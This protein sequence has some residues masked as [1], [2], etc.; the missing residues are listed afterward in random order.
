[1]ASTHANLLEGNKAFTLEKSSTPIG[2]V[3]YINMAAASVLWN[4]NVAVVTS[5]KCALRARCRTWGR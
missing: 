2:L 1:V 5:C 3:W 4:T